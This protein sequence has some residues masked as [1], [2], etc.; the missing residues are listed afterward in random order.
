M[1]S[2]TGQLSQLSVSDL[3]LFLERSNRTG[4]LILQ[5]GAPD[6]RERAQFVF[7]E[8]QLVGARTLATSPLGDLLLRDHEIAPRELAEAIDVQRGEASPATPLGEILVRAGVLTRRALEAAL[9]EQIRAG[10]AGVREW[11][12]GEFEFFEEEVRSSAGHAVHGGEDLPPSGLPP[13]RVLAEAEK[14]FSERSVRDT[15]PV[16]A[17]PAEDPA[18]GAENGAGMIAGK[19]TV[20]RFQYLRAQASSDGGSLALLRL[21]AER[22]ERGLLL[23]PADGRLAV[24]GAFGGGR[25]GLLA[26]SASR[27][28][29][30]DLADAGDLAPWAARG[31][32]RGPQARRQLPPRLADLLPEVIPAEAILLPLIGVAANGNS[33]VVAVVFAESDE[34]MPAEEVEALNAA[35]RD[36][37][38][39]LQGTRAA[40]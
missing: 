22:F 38:T 7:E 30:V 32:W 28:L 35:S 39:A 40:T 33:V 36:L 6:E 4:T 1:S 2:F 14:V 31:P 10:V 19:E 16:M 34:A 27:G 12:E 23:E 5:R 13:L 15:H 37:A 8:G 18:S 11:A 3:F 26:Q 24:L 20:E 9:A 25:E 17:L 29:R 21:I